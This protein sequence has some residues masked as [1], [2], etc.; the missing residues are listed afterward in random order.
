[1]NS[2][3][4][5]SR[6]LLPHQ[7]AL[8]D[9]F[10]S[11]QAS[12]GH[13]ALWEPGLG[14]VW[15]TG[16]II[17]KFRLIQ[18]TGRVLVLSPKALA[19]Q[20]EYHL[21]SI[22]VAA[23]LVDR[24]RYREMQDGSSADNALWR[25]GGVFILGMDFAK[26]DDVATSLRT[27]PWSLLVVLEAH[28]VRGQ[29]ERIVQG[30]VESSPG[31]RMLIFTLPGV[32]DLPQ[33]GIKRWTESTVHQVDVVDA[34]GRRIFDLPQPDVRLFELPQD[35]FEQ[36]LM[37]TVSEV[38]QL[39]APAKRTQGLLAS[40]VKLS[41]QSSLSALEEVLRR[42]RHRLAHG[43]VD[44]LQSVDEHDDETDA[45]ELPLL[46]P[47]ENR[48]LLE[49]LNKC[50]EELDS[51][52]GDSKLKWLTQML[53]DA[54]TRGKLAHSI[55]V[56]V[57]Y[58]A[59]LFYVQTALEELG[60]ATYVLHGALSFD[61]RFEAVRNFQERGGILLATTALMT[62]G[63]NLAKVESLVLYDCPRS[64]LMLQQVLGRF[65]RFGRTEPLTID[66][67]NGGEAI[68]LFGENLSAK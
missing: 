60:L 21:A 42:L 41:A 37:N 17:R 2:D 68:E 28:Q 25:E 35:A 48:A 20:T 40:I 65:Q 64:R 22:G 11:D 47:A 10:L 33:F 23:Q 34:S 43:T 16:H 45:D 5:S 44:T 46:P 57:H 1:M 29:R 52:A 53:V 14:A 15:T 19:V 12:S 3:T 7:Q 49:A 4:Q 36:R 62:E 26:Q 59:T 8:L 31:V 6:P 50:L 55:C 54:K 61:A 39:L 9:E 38:V 24:F 58:R 30:V 18:P 27:V 63:L 67:I 51:L 13:A 66:V 32:K 56:L